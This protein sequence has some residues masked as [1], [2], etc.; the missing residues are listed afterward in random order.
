VN[1]D[2]AMDVVAQFEIRRVLLGPSD[3]QGIVEGATADGRL[4][5]GTDTVIV[6]D[7]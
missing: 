7:K 2:G 4:F 3:I 1:G 5:R 6:L